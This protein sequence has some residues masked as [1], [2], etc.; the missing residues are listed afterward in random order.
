MLPIISV[1]KLSKSYGA[2]SVFEELSVIIQDREKIGLIG[3]NGTGKS[4]FL[5]ILAG[6]EYPD[7]GE[8]VHHKKIHI[9][10]LPQNPVFAEHDTPQT[11]V[12]RALEPRR[13]RICAYEQIC[14]AIS[15]CSCSCS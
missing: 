1:Q 8:I 14:E 4:T 6:L 11:V 7:D 10:Y 5:K 3:H 13:A 12:A 2:K 15:A 9:A